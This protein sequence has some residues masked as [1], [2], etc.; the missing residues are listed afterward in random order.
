MAKLQA[1]LTYVPDPI[2]TTW[3]E[4]SDNSGLLQTESG[5]QWALRLQLV[6]SY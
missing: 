2:A 6:L 3:A 4:G 1:D 5:S